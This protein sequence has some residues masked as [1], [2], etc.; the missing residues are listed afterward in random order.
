MNLRKFFLTI[1]PL[2]SPVSFSEKFRGAVAGGISIFIL[3]WA[4]KLMPHDAYPI[5]LLSSMAASALLLF[6][7]PHSP[8]AQPWNLIGGHL[9]SGFV[10]WLCYLLI[11]D[12]FIAA[13]V[14]VGLSILLMHSFNC[15]H[16][17]GAATAIALALGSAQFQYMGFVGVMTVVAVNAG[18]MLILALLIN[19]LLPGRHYPLRHENLLPTNPGSI[20]ALDQED[21]KMAL[22]QMGEV[23]DISEDDLAQIYMYAQRN[24]DERQKGK[25]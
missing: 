5:S 8:L 11:P 14:A 24:A 23:I 16:P 15:L 6:A 1:F 2:S 22:Q 21:L 3:C 4:F 9:I 10:G 13:S 7:V 20:N 25:S 17:P 19:N 12:I 18:F